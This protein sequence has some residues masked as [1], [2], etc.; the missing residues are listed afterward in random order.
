MHAPLLITLLALPG[1]VLPQDLPPPT[2]VVE[3]PA[4]VLLSLIHI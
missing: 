4:P 3:A 2:A 1:T